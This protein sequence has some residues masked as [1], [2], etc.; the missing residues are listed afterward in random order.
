MFDAEIKEEVY[1]CSKCGLCQ[2]VCPLY[3]ATKNEM[4]LSRGRYIVLNNFFNNGK[5]LTKSFIKNLD[6]CLNCNACK[7]F[8]PSNIDAAAIFTKLK[9]ENNFKFGLFNFSFYYFLYLKLHRFLKRDVLIKRKKRIVKNSND[10]KVV[11]FQ[12]CINKY[13]NPSDKSASLNILEQLNYDVISINNY[14]CGL[15][16]L[17]DGNLKKFQKNSE[18]IVKSIPKDAKYI[19]CSCDSCFD[20]LSKIDEISDK[21]V[22]IDDILK[23]N[24]VDIPCC[25]NALYHKPLIRKEEPFIPEGMPLINKKGSCSLMENFFMLKYKKLTKI[26]IDKVFYKKEE[27]DNKYIITTCQL[28][29]LGLSKGAKAIKSNAKVLSYSE[30]VASGRDFL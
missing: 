24:Y 5:K 3:L 14:C 15:P 1:K 2:S 30:Y 12:G 16:Y 18:K 8:C 11:Y 19:V 17:S 23:M 10:D 6:I 13:V 25:E 22:R 4:F 9:S 7:N 27:L 28:S 21:L 29:K 20:T 26:L